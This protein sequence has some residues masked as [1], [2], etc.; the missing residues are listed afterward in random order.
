MNEIT[1]GWMLMGYGL[2]GVFS[3]LIIFY[4][5]IRC[6]VRFFPERTQESN[7]ADNA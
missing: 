1:L 4:L 2:I 3:V 7:N 6:L 5:T